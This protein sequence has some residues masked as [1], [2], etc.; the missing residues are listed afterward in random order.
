MGVHNTAILQL[1]DQNGIVI[2]YQSFSGNL[3]KEKI[4]EQW[5]RLY[6][7]NKSFQQCE[8]KVVPNDYAAFKKPF[9]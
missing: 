2:R 7:N 9:K 8:F 5:K 6:A 1:V 3:A 4:K